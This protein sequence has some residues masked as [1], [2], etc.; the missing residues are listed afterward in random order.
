MTTIVILNNCCKL[1]STQATIHAM[2]DSLLSV[3]EEG[4]F[5]SNMYKRKLWDGKRHFYNRVTGQFNIGLLSTI[6]DELNKQ[7][8]KYKLVDN[9]VKPLQSTPIVTKLM[10]I[11]SEIFR[12]LRYYQ[13]EAVESLINNVIGVI[14]AATNAGKTEIFSEIIRRLNLS[15]TYICTRK[16]LF[17]Q[18]AERLERRLGVKVGLIG[19]GYQDI[20]KINIVMPTSAVMHKVDAKGKKLKSI[21]IKPELVTILKSDILILDEC[22]TITDDRVALICNQ[23]EAYYRLAGS[24]TPFMKDK[25]SNMKLKA[26]FGKIVYEITNDQL[27][28]IG[29]SAKPNCYFIQTN[30]PDISDASYD[31]AYLL[32]IIQNQERND[33]IVRL[34]AGMRKLNRVGLIITSQLEHLTLLQMAIPNVQIS[35]GA[36]SSKHRMKVLADFTSGK[37]DALIVSNIYDVGIDTD[38]IDYIIMAAG[39]MTPERILQRIGRGI[40]QKESGTLWYFDFLDID[41]EYLLGHSAKRISVLKKEKFLVKKLSAD[42]SELEL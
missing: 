34:V 14:K 1:I 22:Q 10:F 15:V 8:E 11:E 36:C 4:Y 37:I 6:I 27:I 18:T 42:L 33:T 28:N 39:M 7:K 31:L 16:E 23:S 20:Q 19:D 30:C 25:C 29:V 24:G 21:C 26:S 2:L 9:R 32:G 17:H 13:I 40:R 38:K 5:F 12:E 3:Y 41:N 35:H